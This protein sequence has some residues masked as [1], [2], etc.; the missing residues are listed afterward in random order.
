VGTLLAGIFG[1]ALILLVLGLGWQAVWKGI[2]TG[3][4]KAKATLVRG[5]GFFLPGQP[6]DSHAKNPRSFTL[7][8]A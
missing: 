8:K 5:I 7:N 1:I 2:M 6:I 3:A 4:E